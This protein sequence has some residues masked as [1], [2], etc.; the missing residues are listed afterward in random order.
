MPIRQVTPNSEI[1]SYIERK[2]DIWMQIII[3]NF[4]YI[5]EQV[6]NAARSTNSYKDQTGNLRSS[7]GYVVVVDGRVADISSSA[8]VKNGHE[9]SKTGADY[10]RELARKFPKGIVLIVCAGMNY[11]AYVSAK[12]Y[13]VI[14]SAELLAERLVPQMLRKLGLK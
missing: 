12:G 9:G 11:A 5:G 14:D 1:N 2:L 8:V 7:L 4:S 13:D 3:N 6:L 10:A